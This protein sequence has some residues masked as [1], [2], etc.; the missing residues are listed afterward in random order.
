MQ[1]ARDA[2]ESRGASDK[3][4][5]LLPIG[6]GEGVEIRD[7]GA[8]ALRVRASKSFSEELHAQTLSHPAASLLSS[9]SNPVEEIGLS[10]RSGRVKF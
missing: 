5:H 6:F 2:R 9:D 1:A 8:L 4:D 3:V 10:T 7:V